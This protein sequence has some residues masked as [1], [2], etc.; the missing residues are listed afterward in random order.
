[1][2][3]VFL[4]VA[5]VG[6]AIGFGARD[7]VALKTVDKLSR[8]GKTEAAQRVLRLALAV[9]MMPWETG[10]PRGCLIG[11]YAD[12]LGSEE[13]TLAT[14][15]RFL[16]KK[17]N[18]TEQ[19][20]GL[21]NY[22]KLRCLS[23]LQRHEEAWL[24]YQESEKMLKASPNLYASALA[25]HL[26]NGYQIRRVAEAEEL[27]PRA[28]QVCKRY[29]EEQQGSFP[30]ERSVHYSAGMIYRALQRLDSAEQHLKECLRFQSD[31]G[32]ASLLADTYLQLGDLEKARSTLDEAQEQGLPPGAD[33]AFLMATGDLCEALQSFREYAR[34][35]PGIEDQSNSSLQAA[36]SLTEA[37]I[38]LQAENYGEARAVL[39]DAVRAEAGEETFALTM[40]SL[41]VAEAGTGEVEE[42]YSRMAEVEPIGQKSP[43]NRRLQNGLLEARRQ[44]A[45]LDEQH[46]TVS[47][48]SQRC[49]ESSPPL[50]HPKILY[51]WAQSRLAA[52]DSEEARA[53]FQRAAESVPGLHYAKLARK[54]L[55]SL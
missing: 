38:H 22:A 29:D 32:I 25:M 15:S 53:L 20:E 4:L 52:G 12:L 8:G 27:I 16:A 9:P 19:V 31:A 30:L 1:M 17:P 2:P 37:L 5:G 51:Q 11:G 47:E 21:L 36:A 39:T 41:A 3:S 42:A 7:F 23:T 6:G 45:F 28:I 26:L 10:G 33:Y 50:A 54:G 48:L 13:E 55:E 43:K 49:L 46:D 44:I 24:L 34:N 18:L 40:S 14:I 35:S